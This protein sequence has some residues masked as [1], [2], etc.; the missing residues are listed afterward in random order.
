MVKYVAA[1]SQEF[2]KN[3]LGRS[4]KNRAELAKK[5]GVTPSYISQIF[6][7][8]PNTSPPSTERLKQIADALG[9]SETE[10]WELVRLA[11]M[12]RATP[13][14]RELFGRLEQMLARRSSEAGLQLPLLAEVPCDRF[15]WVETHEPYPES[16]D[17][18]PDEFV[19]N[20]F[21]IRARGNSMEKVILD[22]D[23]L[24]F[25]RTKS[26]GNGSVVCAQLSGEAE[27]STIKYYFN[28]GAAV[29]LRPENTDYA[30]MIL[31]K[32]ADNTFLYDDKRVLL[33]IKGVLRSL[34][35]FC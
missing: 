31:V 16:V 26:P 4:G 35:R 9:A 5:I 30:P 22:G 32:S 7:R 29:E 6:G 12:E 17:L 2:L 14:A 21:A 18:A 3:L 10:T 19:K 27:G 11:V 20:G 28:R 25:D 34:K 24:I 23:L 8:Y 15:T 13:E 33:E 1:S